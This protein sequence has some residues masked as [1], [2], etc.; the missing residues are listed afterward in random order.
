M[1]TIAPSDIAIRDRKT[2]LFLQGPVPRGKGA[3]KSTPRFTRS[4]NAAHMI[5]RVDLGRDLSDF[6]FPTREE[7]DAKAQA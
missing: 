4:S 2:G 1:G 5:V 6:D 7:L 3:W